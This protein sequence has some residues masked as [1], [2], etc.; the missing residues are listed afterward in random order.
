MGKQQY[1]FSDNVRF[2]MLP[3]VEQKIITK[4]TNRAATRGIDHTS[5]CTQEIGAMLT[6]FEANSWK[7]GDCLSEI[8]AMHACVDEHKGDPVCLYIYIY[9]YK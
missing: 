3:K 4:S 9:I 5:I 7:T 1:K 6:C 2:G 8:S